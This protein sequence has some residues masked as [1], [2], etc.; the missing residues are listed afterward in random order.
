MLHS[1]IVSIIKTCLRDVGVPEAAI[2]MEARGQRA[3]DRSRPGDVVALDFFADVRHLV[4]DAFITNV[5]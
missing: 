1:G 4:I 2:V 5:Y 3:A